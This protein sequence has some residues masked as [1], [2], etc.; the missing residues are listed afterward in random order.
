MTHFETEIREQPEV[1]ERLLG[2]AGPAAAVRALHERLGGP[3]AQLVTVARGS[4]DHAVSFFGYLAGLYLGLPVASLPPSLITLYGGELR[5]ER[6]LAVGVSQSG[7]SPDVVAGLRA[8]HAAGAAVVAVTNEAGSALTETADAT[9]LLGAGSER[10]VAA[11]K[12]FSAQMMALARLVAELADADELRA[13]LRRVPGALATLFEHER[14]VRDAA[15]RLTHADRAFVLGRGLSFAPA[16]E[17]ALKLKETSYLHA[18]AYSS[19]EFRHGPIASLHEGD[20]VLLLAASD[21]TLPANREA[22]ERLHETGASV[23]VI[24]ADEDLLA[25]AD[26][27]VPLPADLPPVAEAFAHVVAGQLLALRLTEARGRDPDAP[28]HLNKVTRTR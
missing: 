16:Q 13:A 2:D 9:L 14:P 17:L 4:S 19:A 27:A 25:E 22:V 11:S 15:L 20:P 5:L 21:A 8:L 7:E 12:T 24:A 6:A 26:A 3:P 18:E 28:R 1:L 10:A 23:T